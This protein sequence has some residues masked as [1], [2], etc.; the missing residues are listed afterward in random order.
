MKVMLHE[1]QHR[2]DALP[3]CCSPVNQTHT[4]EQRHAEDERNCQD[5]DE[6]HEV[7]VQRKLCSQGLDTIAHEKDG[8]AG[9]DAVVYWRK[10]ARGPHHRLGRLKI[11]LGSRNHLLFFWLGML[12]ENLLRET[13]HVSEPRARATAHA[14]RCGALVDAGKTAGAVWDVAASAA[15]AGTHLPDQLDH[16]VRCQHPST[17][18]S[19]EQS[20]PVLERLRICNNVIDLVRPYDHD[21]LVAL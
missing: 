9:R 18:L 6:P 8:Q 20:S 14:E 10:H 12:V 21:T 5:K 15:G 3:K 16:A 4:E 2:R 13:V 17:S 7:A 1:S 11:C 19:M